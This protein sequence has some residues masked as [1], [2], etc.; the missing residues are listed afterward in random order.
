[1][2][3]GNG[4]NIMG[5]YLINLTWRCQIHCPY[6]LLPHIKI[7]RQCVEHTWQDWV[8]GLC[9]NTPTGSVLDFAGGDPLLFPGLA[10]MLKALAD[11]GRRWAITTNALYTRAVD[12]LILI[13]PDRCA[14]VNVSD[15][16]GNGTDEVDDNI[17]RLRRAFP[18]KVNSVQVMD[19]GHRRRIDDWIPYQSWR[20]G[21]ELDG[22]K[23]RCNSGVY[24]WVVDP[25]GDVFRCNPHMATAQKPI[26]NLFESK[27]VAPEPI[28]CETGCSTCYTSV[29]GAWPVSMEV[30]E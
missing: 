30:I 24:H 20:E 4:E 11:A 26:G 9:E 16:P 21:T 28:I 18:L 17:E 3:G 25:G 29:P 12:E 5:H 13:H 8:V 27:I 22:I 7:N 23:R 14:L 2:D 10:H 6:C 19:A 1:V 15:H